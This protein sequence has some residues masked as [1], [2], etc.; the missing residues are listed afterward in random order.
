V[1]SINLLPVSLGVLIVLT[2]L[3]LVEADI[4]I[5]NGEMASGAAGRTMVELLLKPSVVWPGERELS[6]ALFVEPTWL[7]I[8]CHG[9]TKQDGHPG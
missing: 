9:L 5:T 3:S 8:R 1:L 4:C 2:V 6:I 7:Y